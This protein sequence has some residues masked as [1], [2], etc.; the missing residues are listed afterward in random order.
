MEL[1]SLEDMFSQ[2]A[3]VALQEQVVGV[4]ESDQLIA[5]IPGEAGPLWRRGEARTAS[6]QLC[7]YEVLEVAEGESFVI[8]QGEGYMLNRSAEG[9]LLFLGRSMEEKQLV[10][11]HISRSRWGRTANI[12]E[13]R[14][15]KP[16]QME[17]GETLYL[18]G[19]RRVFGPCD[20]LS[21]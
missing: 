19:G 20:Y 14:W 9:I 10:E 4:A 16:V 15:S 1:R 3:S 7:S 13:V 6:R 11:V 18:L 8:E 2:Y 21:F 17:S 12:F 5:A